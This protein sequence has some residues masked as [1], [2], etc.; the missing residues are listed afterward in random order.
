[1]EDAKRVAFA[2]ALNSSA[3]AVDGDLA[4]DGGQAVGAVGGVIRGSEGVTAADRQVN[5]VRSPSVVG[6]GDGLDEIGDVAANVD[7]IRA[8]HRERDHAQR[9]PGQH[10]GHEEEDGFADQ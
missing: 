3:V 9:Y 6:V 5:G 2:A 8:G 1:M 7:L 10:R 4:D